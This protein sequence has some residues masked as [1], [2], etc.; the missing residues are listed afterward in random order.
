MRAGVFITN[1]GEGLCINIGDGLIKLLQGKLKPQWGVFY[2][3]FLILMNDN[4]PKNI[5]FPDF[6]NLLFI[7]ISLNTCLLLCQKNYRR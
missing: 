3:V 5:N 7:Y 6:L 2:W 1:N 4:A